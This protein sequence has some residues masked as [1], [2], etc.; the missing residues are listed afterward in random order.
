MTEPISTKLSRAI[1]TLEGSFHRLLLLVGPS[2]SG[3][4]AAMHELANSLNI[5]LTNVNLELSKSLLEMTARQRTLQIPK[6]LDQLAD[7]FEQIVL[8]DNTEILFDVHIQQDPLRLLR[9]LS[10]K[11]TVVSTWHGS[12]QNRRLCYAEP[13]HPEYRCYEL[14]DLMYVSAFENLEN[15][16]SIINPYKAGI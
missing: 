14:G 1:E 8:F 6:L 2:Q 12:V 15:T 5:N 13:G 3:K 4:T 10:R 16:E 11:K 9:G 7:G